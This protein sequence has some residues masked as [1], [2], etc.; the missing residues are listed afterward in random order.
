M[1]PYEYRV[2]VRY[3]YASGTA[4]VRTGYLKMNRYVLNIRYVGGTVLGTH[5]VRTGYVL[6]ILELVYNYKGI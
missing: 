2:H 4:P 5:P 6:A 3:G 1:L